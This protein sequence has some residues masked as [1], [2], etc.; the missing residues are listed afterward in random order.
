MDSLDLDLEFKKSPEKTMPEKL[1]V[2]PDKKIK[3][4]STPSIR[5]TIDPHNI[6]DDDSMYTNRKSVD[7]ELPFQLD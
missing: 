4:T 6:S 1:K 3:L 2:S 5:M 7:H